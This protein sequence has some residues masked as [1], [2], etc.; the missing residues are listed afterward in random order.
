MLLFQLSGCRGKDD[1]PA[2][3][4]TPSKMR[5]VMWEIFQADY[6]SEQFVRKDSLRDAVLE[7]AGMQD[8]IFRRHGVSR[9]Q[10]EDSYRFYSGHPDLM[11][12]LMDS[13]TA[14]GEHQRNLLMQK[15]YARPDSIGN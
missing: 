5:N 2:D 15:R 3:L 9:K 1:I 12:A 13:I 7:N 14:S 4:L 8:R 6:Y 11:K 10:Y